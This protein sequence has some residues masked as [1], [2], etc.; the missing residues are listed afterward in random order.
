MRRVLVSAVVLAFGLAA[1]AAPGADEHGHG[2][3]ALRYKA[4]IHNHETDKHEQKSF[5]LSKAEDHEALAGHIAKGEVHELVKDEP[6]NIL[7]LS[8]DLGLW[9]LVV[10]I[11]LYLILRKLAWKPM[12][13]AAGWLVLV[14]FALVVPMRRFARA[15]HQAP[16]RIRLCRARTPTSSSTI[17]GS[18]GT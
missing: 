14:T 15:N 16:S 2:K 5:D 7:A 3:K 18:R 6:V 9:T 1:S 17:R 10:F 12:L 4:E 13:N 11:L 8:W